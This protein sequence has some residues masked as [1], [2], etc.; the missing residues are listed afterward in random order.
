MPIVYRN[1]LGAFSQDL[2]RIPFLL[3]GY[4]DP[5]AMPREKRN[6]SEMRAWQNSLR[7][8]HDAIVHSGDPLP[9]S[10][11]VMIEYKLPLTERR[12]DLILT[13]EDNQGNGNCVIIELKQWSDAE[14]VPDKPGVVIAT[15]GNST[16][17]ETN[18]PCYQ[19]WSYASYLATMNLNVQQAC[20]RPDAC[21]FMHN[22]WYQGEN[23]PLAVEPNRE[24]VAKT[25]IYGLN[26]FRNLHQHLERKIGC[27]NGQKLLDLI[28][29][30][31]IVP[32][33]RLIDT[34]CDV[35]DKTSPRYFTL[36][37]E[38]HL[39]YQT[40]M[41]AARK[42]PTKGN[43]RCVIIKG[44]PGTG[45]SVVAVKALVDLLR[46]HRQSESGR[47]I[48]FISPTASFRS[49]VVDMLGSG[50]RQR[51]EDFVRTK[52][53]IKNLFCGSAVF[54][55][56]KTDPVPM[57][58]RY[59]VLICDES[60][61][62]HSQ[63]NYYKGENQ[64]EDIIN[65]AKVSVFFV[66]DNQ[67]L[68]PND[69]GS[70]NS[71]RDAAAKF[72]AEVQ[73]VELTAQFRCGGANGFLNWLSDVFGLSS[74]PTANATGW[75]KADFDFDI[76]ETPEE[77]IRFVE[78]KNTAAT[79]NLN[80]PGRAVFPGAR[81]LAGYAWP[82]SQYD[83]KTKDLPLDVDLGTVRLPWNSRN[84]SYDWALDPTRTNEVGCVHTSQ[85]LEFEY[86]GV[87]IGPDLRYDPETK[88][89]WAD[90]RRYCDTGGK[91]NLGKGEERDRE[92]LKYVCRCYR[93]L[94]SRGVRGARVWCADP[95]LGRMLR[96][97]LAQSLDLSED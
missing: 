13:G 12:V 57:K 22:Y 44:G 33:T 85:G 18:H 2:P 28:A 36:L 47:N 50:D 61:R 63:Q 10:C 46:Y 92:L 35:F 24:L 53:Q 65:A 16:R 81:M 14:P 67:A 58:D 34:L 52:T 17:R 84:A 20:I 19:A 72:G 62:L 1:T 51:R 77:I 30:G 64:I 4:E 87:F 45:K 39:A 97:S 40:I 60:H 80:I 27:G 75:R 43:K 78:A 54:F 69:I 5:A 26:G 32:G 9:D 86:V 71:I 25:P 93:V 74:T 3:A 95:N 41:Q 49:A 56:T 91:V 31:R 96:E 83:S 8:A 89:L 21:A 11:G 90:Y 42:L 88:K 29:D 7:A 55:D 82:W 73:T 6:T 23:D 68:R 94:L 76:V 38:Q 37:D 79:Q 66:D 59:S 48:R 70:E 15:V